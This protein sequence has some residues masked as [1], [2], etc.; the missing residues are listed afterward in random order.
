MHLL[1]ELLALVA[2]ASLGIF[3]GAMLTEGLVLLPYWRSITAEAFYSW[4]GANDKRLL[5]FFG[6]LTWLAALTAL[7]AADLVVDDPPRALVCGGRC[8]VCAHGR[9]DVLPLF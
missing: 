2:V 9:L 6:P 8:R 5:G 7:A 4:Y 1:G 3:F